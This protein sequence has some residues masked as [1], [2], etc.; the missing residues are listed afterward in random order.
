ME[1]AEQTLEKKMALLK[2]GLT[3]RLH[4]GDPT[5]KQKR[6]LRGHGVPQGAHEPQNRGHIPYAFTFPIRY[7]HPEAC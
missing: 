6:G 2:D 7:M 3:P 5:L 1:A 4:S